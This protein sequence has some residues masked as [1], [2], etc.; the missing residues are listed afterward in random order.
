ML[1][2]KSAKQLIISANLERIDKVYTSNLPKE[3]VSNTN[4]TI[5]LITDVDTEPDLMGN[6]TFY[7]L[8]KQ[9]EVQIFYKLA[10]DYDPE[11]LETPLMKL[12]T[13]NHWQISD[14]KQHT[15]DPDTSQMSVAFYFTKT[16]LTEG[17]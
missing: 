13:S 12:F 10:M 3:E 9:V 8:S 2:V 5:L 4:E 15:I 7:A 16:D 1:A 17:D 11:E 6:N 14:I